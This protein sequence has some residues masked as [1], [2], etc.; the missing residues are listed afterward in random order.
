MLL[1]H[2]CVAIIICGN[3][4]A[5]RKRMTTKN[6]SNNA[7]TTNDSKIL[8][9]FKKRN[10]FPEAWEC[11][12]QTVTKSTNYDLLRTKNWQNHST[13][14]YLTV[15]YFNVSTSF[16]KKKKMWNQTIEWNTQIQRERESRNLSNY[17]S[18]LR[19]NFQCSS[20]CL[21]IDGFCITYAVYLFGVWH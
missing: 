14:C 8:K 16:K 7:T 18:L 2:K 11:H 9:G 6:S 13:I 21:F 20:Y 17:L 19:W 10:E 1:P 15:Y 12:S 4:L 5:T 3:S